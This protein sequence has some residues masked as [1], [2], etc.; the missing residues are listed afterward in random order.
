V[1]IAVFVREFACACAVCACGIFYQHMRARASAS[2][3]LFVLVTDEIGY[4]CVNTYIIGIH[5]HIRYIF[6]CSFITFNMRKQQR[7]HA[8]LNRLSPHEEAEN[9]TWAPGQSDDFEPSG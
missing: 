2:A 8:D 3:C 9:E 6:A 7:M 5:V 4:V 1:C